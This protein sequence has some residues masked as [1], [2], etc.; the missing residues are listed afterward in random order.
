MS[1]MVMSELKECPFCGSDEKKNIWICPK[2]YFVECC[3]CGACTKESYERWNTRYTKPSDEEKFPH[4]GNLE[5]IKEHFINT[6]KSWKDNFI[7]LVDDCD[8]SLGGISPKWK[9]VAKNHI[10]LTAKAFEKAIVNPDEEPSVLTVDELPGSGYG[11]GVGE[12]GVKNLIR[13]HCCFC[14]ELIYDGIGYITCNCITNPKWSEEQMK[15]KFEKENSL[16]I[17]MIRID[18]Y[19]DIENQS[20]ALREMGKFFEAESKEDEGL[21]D[22]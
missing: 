19:R 21:K 1:G 3:K 9:L 6:L 11:H 7:E 22:E 15:F 10:E 5:Q 14:G 8:N 20:S 4:F 13:K 2:G 18:S 16:N 17:N 12:Y